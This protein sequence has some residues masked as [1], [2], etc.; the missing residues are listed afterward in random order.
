MQYLKRSGYPSLIVT[1]MLALLGLPSLS[2]GTTSPQLIEQLVEGEVTRQLEVQHIRQR[3]GQRVSF[4]LSQIDPRLRL[5]DCGAPITVDLGTGKLLGRVT[6]KVECKSPSPWTIYVPLTIQVFKKVVTI[7][8]PATAGKLLEHNDLQLS[9]QEVS[10]LTQGYFTQIKQVSNKLLKRS[11]TMNGVITPRMIEEPKVVKKG[12]EVM[13]VATKGALS[14]RS[15]GVALSDGRVG[16]QIS[17][18]NSATKRI[19]KARVKRKGL[20]QVII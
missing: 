16:Q 11:I 20:V 7:R 13:I 4:Q 10:S 19:V 17:V 5:A 2:S 9:E 8:A 6:A 12:D 14:V 3:P 15:P 18:K 1:L